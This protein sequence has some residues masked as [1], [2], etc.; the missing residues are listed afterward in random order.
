MST[1]TTAP[2]PNLSLSRGAAIEYKA[3]ARRFQPNI[4][5]AV[6][7]LMATCYYDTSGF[8]ISFQKTADG[9]EL[10]EQPPTGIFTNLVTYYVASWTSGVEA[11]ATATTSHVTVTD[12]FGQH[13]VHV[14]DW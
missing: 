7:I 4:D 14:K 10:V 11:V 6:L 9:F 1:A 2:T 8:A 12:S 3:Y 5:A 13:R